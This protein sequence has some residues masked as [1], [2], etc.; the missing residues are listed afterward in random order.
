ML[1][2]EWFVADV[3]KEAKVMLPGYEVR[4]DVVEKYGRNYEAFVVTGNGGVSMMVN[5]EEV[6]KAYAGK[7]L[8]FEEVID[9]LVE[10]VQD[11][12]TIN[13]EFVDDWSR[14]K[15][16]LFFACF[17]YDEKMAEKVPCEVITNDKGCGIMVVSKFLY[18][19]DKHG[20]GSVT[21]NNKMLE[22]WGIDK[23]QLKAATLESGPKLFPVEVKNLIDLTS[24]DDS[25]PGY[26]VVTNKEMVDGAGSIFYPEVI[27]R[28]QSRLFGSRDFLI[29]PSS[30]HEVIVAPD[31]GE[32]DYA[33]IRS[34]VQMVN[35]SGDC[36]SERDF[37]SNELFR[38]NFKKGKIEVV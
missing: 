37:L 23:E 38:Y 33:F 21:V 10:M 26:L 11:M 8:S 17:P 14:I 34:M 22:N 9:Q 1:N 24:Y 32:A 5:A 18:Y 7:E 13:R 28:V 30:R 27:S 6:Y 29:I 4:F 31:S 2:F 19:M 3:V 36:V 25:V 20:F 16:L 12:P 35:A 15:N